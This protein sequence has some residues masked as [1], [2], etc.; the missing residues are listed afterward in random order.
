MAGS[1]AIIVG[2][3]PGLGAALARRFAKG[4]YSVALVA[5]RVETITSVQ[6][7]IEAEGGKAAC[8]A[9]DSTVEDQVNGAF[10]KI[11]TELGEPEVLCYNVGPSVGSSWPPP[12]VEEM[13]AESFRQGLETGALGAF[14]WCKQILPLVKAAKKGTILLT[15]ATAGLRGGANFSCLS[16]GKFALRSLSQTL[17]RELGPHKVHVAH[18]IVD[19]LIGSDKVKKLMPDKKEEELLNADAMANEYWNLHVQDPTTWSQEV[20]LRPYT[21]KF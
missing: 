13:S 10:A 20:D 9:A 12:L 2:V 3:G 6:E 4:G 14:L 18:V 8:F 11:R 7:S 1:C 17:A 5:R 21:E 16:P 15:G 19:G